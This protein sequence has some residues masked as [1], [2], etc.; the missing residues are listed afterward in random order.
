MIRFVDL[1]P[2]YWTLG[3]SPIC[4]F[5]STVTNKFITDN[6]GSHTFD[7]AADVGTIPDPETRARCAGL[8]PR[9]FWD[10]NEVDALRNAVAR[11]EADVADL[12]AALASEAQRR[13][14]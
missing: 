5:L 10:A 13:G 8:V 14:P 6:T 3:G 4:A 11:I 2:F 7:S 9:G 12:T 1:T